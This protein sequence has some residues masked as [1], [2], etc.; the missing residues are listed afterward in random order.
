VGE[1]T[2]AMA[3][4][5]D[6]LYDRLPETSRTA[7]RTAIR[8]KG[9][10]ASMVPGQNNWL[11]VT[12]NWNQVCNAGMV[13]GAMATYEDDPTTARLIINRALDSVVLPM[14]D[15]FPDGAYPEGYGYW[16]YGTT[17]NVLLVSALENLFGSAFGLVEKQGFLQTPAYLVNMVGSSGLPFNYSDAGSRA[18]ELQPAMFWFAQRL[19]DPSLLWIERRFLEQGNFK[20]GVKDRVLPAAML[21]LGNTDLSGITPP[22]AT[23]WSGQGKNPVALM[24]TSWTDPDAIYVGV[25]GGSPSVSHAHMDVGS[26]VMDAD[27][28][29]WAMDNAGGCSATATGCITPSP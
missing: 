19:K 6:W 13:Y 14:A 24:R 3:I 15:Y 16:G 2:M 7:I 18:G 10:D 9:I 1:M 27:G 21:W 22:K 26:F 29:R 28:V 4:G 25:K 12:N 5:Y 17:F 11:K 20:D 8:Q 23:M